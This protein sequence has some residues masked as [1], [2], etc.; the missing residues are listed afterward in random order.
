MIIGLCIDVSASELR[1]HLA[2]RADYHE[3][4]SKWYA[5]HAT[6]LRKGGVPSGMSNDPVRSLEESEQRHRE[7]AAF[8]RFMEQHIIGNE[9]YRLSQEDL[10]QIELASRFY[11][12]AHW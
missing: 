11:P 3:K 1:Q 12:G 8:F 7:K 6:G 10:G 2:A 5:D 4:K 9:T